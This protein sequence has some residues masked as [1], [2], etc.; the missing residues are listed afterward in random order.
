[1]SDSPRQALV[2]SLAMNGV[3]QATGFAGHQRSPC[4]LSI[5]GLI[6]RYRLSHLNFGSALIDLDCRERP[7]RVIVKLWNRVNF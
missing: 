7:G 2:S 1:M 4:R 5:H 3:S 6:K